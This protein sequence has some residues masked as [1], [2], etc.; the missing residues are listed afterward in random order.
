MPTSR[1]VN[2]ALPHSQQFTE[3]ESTM[4]IIGLF[5]LCGSNRLVTILLWKNHCQNLLQS[6][7]KMVLSFGKVVEVTV[8]AACEGCAH[9]NPNSNAQI[10]GRQRM[11]SLN[12]RHEQSVKCGYVAIPKKREGIVYYIDE[13]G[14]T[15]SDSVYLT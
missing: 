7:G 1:S 15:A 14:K 11:R 4:Y 8:M 2:A 6:R 10:N 3:N 12:Y 5:V 13:H 9:W